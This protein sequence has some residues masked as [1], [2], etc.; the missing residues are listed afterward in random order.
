MVDF[1]SRQRTGN[2]NPVVT[3]DSKWT[4]VGSSSRPWFPKYFKERLNVCF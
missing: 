4:Q 2:E 1:L 3:A